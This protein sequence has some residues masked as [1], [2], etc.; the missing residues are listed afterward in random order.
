MTVSL[1]KSAFLDG[2]GDQWLA[3]NRRALEADNAQRD[4]V[5]ERVARQLAPEHRAT[6]L[7]IGCG[8]GVN[9]ERLASLR[10]IQAHGID[11]SR[12]AVAAGQAR[13]AALS[14]RVATADAL[15]YDDATFD[16]VWFGFCL[17]LIDRPLLLRVVAEAD[18]VLRDGGLLAILDFDPAAPCRRIY[19]HLPHLHSYKMDH[20]RLFLANP[21]YVLVEKISMQHDSAAWTADPQERV[22]LSLCRK[23]LEQAYSLT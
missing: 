2:E 21:A 14:L 6:V 10:P 5:V 11:P 23:A 22:A 8:Q 1:Q 4:A 19:H 9:L 20:A 15:P 3:R 16:V 18:R 12:E 13:N 7:E 17:Y